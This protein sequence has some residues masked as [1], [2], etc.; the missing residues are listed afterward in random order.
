MY[1]ISNS[2]R[3][4]EGEGLSYP[5]DT[6]TV[7]KTIWNP[8]PVIGLV[9]RAV[10]AVVLRSP[11]SFF[12]VTES[13]NIGPPPMVPLEWRWL[14]FPYSTISVPLRLPD[15]FPEVSLEKAVLTRRPG[16]GYFRRGALLLC[17]YSTD[18]TLLI[19]K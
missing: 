11:P 12:Y 3:R 2:K 14:V 8:H 4:N 10:T 7:D 6:F 17:C 13:K 19:H 15:P 16:V 18:T 9:S 5:Y 1:F